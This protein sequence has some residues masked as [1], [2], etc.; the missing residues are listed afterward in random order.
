MKETNGIPPPGCSRV[1]FTL[2][3]RLGGLSQK[4]I[5][6]RVRCLTAGLVCLPLPRLGSLF[7]NRNGRRFVLDALQIEEKFW[8][9]LSL[10]L[11][12]APTV[13]P[14]LKVKQISTISLFAIESRLPHIRSLCLSAYVSGND[15]KIQPS[16]LRLA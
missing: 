15:Q 7:N 2:A 5:A 11:V 8:A 10:S 12:S 3:E 14:S 16:R 9:T 13:A 6:E 4:S 1:A